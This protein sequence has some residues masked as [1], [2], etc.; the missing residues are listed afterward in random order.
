MF[1]S[2]FLDFFGIVKL[3]VIRKEVS[4]EVVS[5]YLV[6]IIW[7]EL[8]TILRWS[9]GSANWRMAWLWLGGLAGTFLL[10]IDH[11][12]YWFYY[13]PEKQDSQI[14]K[15]LWQKR[16]F[17]GLL[18]LLGR[19]H[20]THT[21]LVFHSFL[22]QM[23]LLI[24][25]FYIFSSVGSYFGSGLAAALNLH[26]LKDEWEEFFEK[27]YDHLND[28]LFWQIKKEVSFSSQKIYLILVTLIF[29]IFSLIM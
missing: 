2:T 26:L 20:D 3:T 22:F 12:L 21:R 5:H 4:R 27:K 19:Y 28:W 25:T 13:H 14:A 29:I 10:D 15:I 9:V 7:L 8:I 16:D 18:M 6:T 17:K 1:F 23:V 11:F 24:F